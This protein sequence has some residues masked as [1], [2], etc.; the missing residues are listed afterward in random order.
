MSDGGRLAYRGFKYQ[1]E[2]STWLCLHLLSNKTCDRVLIEPPNGEDL[3]AHLKQ[4]A[5]GPESSPDVPTPAVG[6]RG[7]PLL[8]QV[9]TRSYG[10]WLAS[11]LNEMLTGRLAPRAATPSP[12]GRV[13][14]KEVLAGDPS[15]LFL[16]VTNSSVD[17]ALAP[18]VVEDPLFALR[19]VV[20]E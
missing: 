6:I 20:C 1:L 10:A 9:K 8:V 14:P 19:F 7:G 11:D 3:Q 15:A 4:E 2:I 17:D 12:A 5:S 16:F 18:L 13:W